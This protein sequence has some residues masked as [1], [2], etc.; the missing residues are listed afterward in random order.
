MPFGSRGTT[1]GCSGQSRSELF[2]DSKNLR[3]SGLF[4]WSGLTPDGSAL[5]VRDVSSDE[6]CSLDVELS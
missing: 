5:F 6:I 3:R 1:A 4:L 2:V